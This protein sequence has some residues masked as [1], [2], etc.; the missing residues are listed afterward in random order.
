MAILFQTQRLHK[1]IYVQTRMD[2]LVHLHDNIID[3]YRHLTTQKIG[4]RVGV[5]QTKAISAV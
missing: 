5:G 1:C 4:V 3:Q 2:A